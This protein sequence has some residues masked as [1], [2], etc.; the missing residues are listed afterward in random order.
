M[1]CDGTFYH[2]LE[3]LRY[4]NANSSY[5]M[6]ILEFIFKLRRYCLRTTFVFGQFLWNEMENY[7]IQ[8]PNRAF[9]WYRRWATLLTGYF[10]PCLIKHLSRLA[11]SRWLDNLLTHRQCVSWRHTFLFFINSK[12]VNGVL[13]YRAQ[14]PCRM[15][16]LARPLSEI[17][18]F[19]GDSYHT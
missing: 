18:L 5:R 9:G 13:M 16:E 1:L 14:L 2:Y 19:I 4:F 12:L 3:Y 6:A 8:V 17:K 10:F 11:W 15:S 7:K